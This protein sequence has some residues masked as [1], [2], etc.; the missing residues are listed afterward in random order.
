MKMKYYMDINK[1]RKNKSKWIETE[2][3]LRYQL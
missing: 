3:I 1:K 2:Y